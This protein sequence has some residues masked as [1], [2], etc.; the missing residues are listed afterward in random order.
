MNLSYQAVK[1]NKQSVLGKFEELDT[2]YS[3]DT[4]PKENF[5]DQKVLPRHLHILLENASPR[6]SEAEKKMLSKN[7]V[8]KAP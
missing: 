8:Q 3:E 4:H 1:I 7:K 2:V 6:L 5:T